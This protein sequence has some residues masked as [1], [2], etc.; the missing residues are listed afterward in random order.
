MIIKE[1]CLEG[2]KQFCAKIA[3]AAVAIKNFLGRAVRCIFCCEGTTQKTK[4]VGSS[5]LKGS[6][7]QKAQNFLGSFNAKINQQHPPVQEASGLNALN[8]T[9]VPE[10]CELIFNSE[11]RQAY[12]LSKSNGWEWSKCQVVRPA[13]NPSHQLTTEAGRYLSPSEALN[14]G[15][16]PVILVMPHGEDS[17][18]YYVQSG[19]DEKPKWIEQANTVAMSGRVF[20]SIFPTSAKQQYSGEE[21]TKLLKGKAI[22]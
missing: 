2:A 18:G 12:V 10:S 5:A 14:H 19:S 22:L 9:A 11:D 20:R 15:F 17:L 21:M 1:I 4:E 7:V 8:R 3:N 6:R 13:L 16:E